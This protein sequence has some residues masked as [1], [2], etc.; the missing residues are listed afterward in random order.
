MGLRKRPTVNARNGFL[1]KEE[2]G[3]S[4]E[5]GKFRQE[6]ATNSNY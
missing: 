2:K 6:F 4:R 3:R 5:K 1:W